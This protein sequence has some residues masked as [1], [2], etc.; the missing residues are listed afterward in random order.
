[1]INDVTNNCI[2]KEDRLHSLKIMFGVLLE[3]E[4]I[5]DCSFKYMSDMKYGTINIMWKYDWNI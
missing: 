3:T 4:C 2:L 1:M 5:S